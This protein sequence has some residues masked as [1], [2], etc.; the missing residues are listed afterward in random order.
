M[1]SRLKD[2][3]DETRKKLEEMRN[4]ELAKNEYDKDEMKKIVT[5]ISE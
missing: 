3:F 1:K 5:I 2:Y 4:E